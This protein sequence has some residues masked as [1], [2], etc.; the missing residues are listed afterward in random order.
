MESLRSLVASIPRYTEDVIRGALRT[1]M[2][3]ELVWIV[4]EDYDD[5]NLYERLFVGGATRIQTSA[6]K[7]PKSEEGVLKG[8]EHVERI[9]SAILADSPQARVCGIR[10]TDYTRY[11]AGYVCPQGIF[12]TEQRDLEMMMIVSESVTDVLKAWNKI[13]P[14]KI[15]ECAKEVRKL[16]Y[17]R[18]YN[19]VKNLGVKIDGLVKR[20]DVWDQNKHQIKDGWF[21]AAVHRMVSINPTASEAELQ[22]TI[23]ELGLE[24]VAYENIC[25]GHDF[26]GLL[27]QMMI[28]NH[29]Y[30]Y[31]A[32]LNKMTTTYTME[33]FKQTSLYVTLDEWKHAKGW[34]EIFNA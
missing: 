8:C 3:A 5:V 26:I 12:H 32:I 2:G 23:E 27:Q 17:I 14:D 4:V 15:E 1:D 21:E 20:Q 10:D 9:V 34:P 7:D 18:V 25:Q 31:E 33:D 6:D 22:K 16:G 24:G 11:L 13:F 29:I 28:Q 19:D 30:S